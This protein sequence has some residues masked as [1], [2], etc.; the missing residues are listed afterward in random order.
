MNPLRLAFAAFA[1][2]AGL[3]IAPAASGQD[4]PL[5]IE[6]RGGAVLPVAAFRT[7]PDAGGEIT[8]APSFGAHFIYRGPS[9]WGPYMGFSQHRFDCVADGCPGE[10]YVATTWDLGME[11]IL[12]GHAWARA[13]VL[14]GRLERDFHGTGADSGRLLHRASSLS[15][16]AE[17]GIGLRVD[18]RGRMG[19]S[20]GLCYGW[21]NTRFRDDG[22]VRMRWVAGDLGIALGF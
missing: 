17:V 13:G 2:F 18:L 19:L 16:G 20:P 3:A 10:K 8:R 22:L 4:A 21:L 9:G 1:A 11:R 12:A 7:G 6:A 5:A 15:L 14:F